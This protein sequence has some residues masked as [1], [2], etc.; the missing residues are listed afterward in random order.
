[1]VFYLPSPTLALPPTIMVKPPLVPCESRSLSDR[2]RS[3]GNVP[4]TSCAL[5]LSTVTANS[6]ETWT[7]GQII[8][9][10]D[11]LCQVQ[12]RLGRPY[13]GIDL[14]KD[15]RECAMK[16]TRITIVVLWALSILPLAPLEAKA[17]V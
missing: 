7:D 10:N 17:G 16:V 8:R 11:Q 4:K 1:M 2:R 12:V 6:I 5:G 3:L 15:E 14:A 9:Q 13:R